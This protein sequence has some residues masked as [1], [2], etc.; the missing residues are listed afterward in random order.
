LPLPESGFVPGCG[1][2]PGHVAVSGLAP[3]TLL[4]EGVDCFNHRAYWEA[5]EVWE[6]AWRARAGDPFARPLL[7]GLI[8]Q[9]A[10][11]VK[12]R[13]GNEA[14]AESLWRRGSGYLSS[15]LELADCPA[16]LDIR[17]LMTDVGAHLGGGPWPS[18]RWVSRPR[19]APPVRVVGAV[20]IRDGRMLV[21]RRR[22]ELARGGK[23]EIPG[24]KVEWGESDQRAIEREM[25]EE[26]GVTV[27]AGAVLAECEHSYPDVQIRLVA[28]EAV[29]RAGELRLVD[30]DAVAWVD[31]DGL[32]SLDW[33]PADMPLLPACREAL[34]RPTDG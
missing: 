17:A 26:L 1:P 2:H 6:A 22:T 28:V 19:L 29:L 8:Q 12:R 21:A 25:E 32:S 34:R 27:S 16:G 4:R 7:Q 5:H 18:L 3:D 23:W 14:A 20:L 30:H 31:A 9:A 13:M 11:V 24:G 15:A 10:A 33:A